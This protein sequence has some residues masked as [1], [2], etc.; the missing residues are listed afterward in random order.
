MLMN[1]RPL[2]L[3]MLI[4]YY[5]LTFLQ[6]SNTPAPSGISILV[7]TI[8]TTQ[9]LNPPNLLIFLSFSVLAMGYDNHFTGVFFKIHSL[10]PLPLLYSRPSESLAR[11]IITASWL[12]SGAS[13]CLSLFLFRNRRRRGGGSSGS[14]YSSGPMSEPWP[15]K[16]E[17]AGP[18]APVK[19][20]S[21]S[22]C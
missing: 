11:T 22:H 20:L 2:S 1:P 17:E 8:P 4:F 6:K 15:G 18:T 7:N 19:W 3:V 10:T 13:L 5:P 16:Q 9:P 14:C 21:P 12:N